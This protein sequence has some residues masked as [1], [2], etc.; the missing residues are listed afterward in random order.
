M[1]ACIHIARWLWRGAQYEKLFADYWIGEFSVHRERCL[2]D[3]RA[4]RAPR[5]VYDYNARGGWVPLDALGRH[6][7]T[8]VWTNDAARG[9]RR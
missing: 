6:K 4:R 5:Y 8:P 1:R 3:E 2:A 7:A 9:G